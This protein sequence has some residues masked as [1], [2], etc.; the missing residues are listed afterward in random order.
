MRT[1]DWETLLS[2]VAVVY[3]LAWTTIP[4]TANADPL[5][6]VSANVIST[7]ALLEALRQRAHPPRLVFV[8]SGGTVYG[9]LR[10]VPVSEDHPLSPI[11]AYGASKAAAELYLGHYRALHGIDCRVARVANPFGAG[12]DVSRGQGAA[13]TFIHCALTGRPIFIWGNGEVVRDYIHVSDAAAGIVA[14]AEAEELDGKWVF[15]IGSGRGV[16][17]NRIVAE[18]ETRFGRTLLVHRELGRSFDVPVSVLDIT[19]AKTLLGWS[20]RLS[21]SDG[22]GITLDELQ[23]EMT[24]STVG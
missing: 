22:I 11:T 16:S 7:I 10:S 13:T 5:G 24:L 19:R 20:P 21:F 9:K 1:A 3:H 23:R 12:Q 4:E 15:N 2:D 8:S 6:D 17:L 14:L 18:L